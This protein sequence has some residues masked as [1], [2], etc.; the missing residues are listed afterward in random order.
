MLMASSL[1]AKKQLYLVTRRVQQTPLFQ[2]RSFN[3]RLLLNPFSANRHKRPKWMENNCRE[4]TERK[5]NKNETEM[6]KSSIL[7][8]F[9]LVA[10]I[11][12]ISAVNQEN[13]KEALYKR[14]SLILTFKKNS[15]QFE[16]TQ[17]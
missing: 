2:R 16:M 15:K 6:E 13:K 12:V 8:G 10:G 7:L 14:T 4:D 3:G 17:G 9:I 1:K 5:Q 11:C